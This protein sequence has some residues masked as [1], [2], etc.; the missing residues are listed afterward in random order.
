MSAGKKDIV[1]VADKVVAQMQTSL[2]AKLNSLDTEYNDG[3]VLED[4]PNGSMFVAEPAKVTDIPLMV[5]IPNRTDAHP[6]DG[7]SRYDIETHDLLVGVA[8]GGNMNPDRLKRIAGRYARAVEEVIIDNRTLSGSVEDAVVLSKDYGPMMADRGSVLL[9]E[10]Q[11][12]VRVI[13]ML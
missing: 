2:P 6:T 4:I 3:I 9:Q 1:W 5:V 11:V 7:R 12:G 10:V 13:T 8:A